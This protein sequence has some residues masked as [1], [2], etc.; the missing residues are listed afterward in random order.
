VVGVNSLTFQFGSQQTM[1]VD[2]VYMTP[3]PPRRMVAAWIALEDVRPDSGPLEYWPQSHQL[4]PF[5]WD[6]PY[7]YH[8][9]PPEQPEHASYLTA[10]Q[11]RFRHERFMAKKGDVLL[12][13][14]MLAH[15]GSPI[16]DK[17]RTRLSMA[18]HYF[19]REC[20]GES[21]SELE[22]HR[23]AW[24]TKAAIEDPD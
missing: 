2:H 19:S 3:N 12:W 18:C 17:T 6:N 21:V 9:S 1:H 20:Y 15:G 16:E 13:H 8:Y 4:P 24:T 22:R 11:H 10:Q 5:K 14:S 7:P 23:T